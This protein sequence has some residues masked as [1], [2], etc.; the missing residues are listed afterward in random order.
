[1]TLVRGMNAC[2]GVKTRS[3]P[4]RF[5]VPATA[6]ETFGI[7]E[8]AA[9]GVENDT[10]ICE[11]GATPTAPDAGVIDTTDSGATGTDRGDVVVVTIPAT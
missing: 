1:M 6:G 5:H 7:V 8:L 11:S 3:V 4:R 2:F 9:S 10:V